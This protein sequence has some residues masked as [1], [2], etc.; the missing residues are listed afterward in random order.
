[1]Q[2]NIISA[3]PAAQDQKEIPGQDMPDALAG[4]H[5]ASEA[6]EESQ[7]KPPKTNCR[8]DPEADVSCSQ[9]AEGLEDHL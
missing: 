4:P 2:L 7:E 6:V 8:N 9:A 3:D 1:M 5:F